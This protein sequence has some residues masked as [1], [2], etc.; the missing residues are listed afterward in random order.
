MQR[1]PAM[2]DGG[3]HRRAVFRRGAPGIS[4]LRIDLADRHMTG[5]VGIDRI[6]QLKQLA[7]GGLGCCEQAIVLVFMSAA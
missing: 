3:G 1:E 2:R 6:R 5:M 7:L 4:E